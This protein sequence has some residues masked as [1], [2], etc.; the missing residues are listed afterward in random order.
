VG[1]PADEREQDQA[2]GYQQIEHVDDGGDGAMAL[3]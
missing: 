2:E 1:T 3:A